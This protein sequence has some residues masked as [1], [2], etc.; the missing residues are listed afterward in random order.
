MTIAAAGTM[1]EATKVSSLSQA[2]T[3][4]DQGSNRDFPGEATVI[5]SIANFA[6]PVF[7]E[8]PSREAKEAN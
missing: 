6:T 5:R 3:E 4:F 7:F 1:A 2:A 8:F